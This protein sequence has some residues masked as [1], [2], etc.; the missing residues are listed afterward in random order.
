MF[1]KS[2]T[3]KI[4]LLQLVM[5]FLSGI[6]ANAQ[7]P[8]LVLEND[9][10]RAVFNARTGAL[11]KLVDKATDWDIQ[12]HEEFALSFEMLVPLKERRDNMVDGNKQAVRSYRI[13]AA[14]DSIVFLWDR[15]Q[16][17]HALDLPIRVIG[18]ASLNQGGLTFNMKIVNQS[19]Y[20]VEA[21]S[22]PSVGEITQPSADEPLYRMHQ[23][24]YNAETTPLLPLFYWGDGYWGVD[25][26]SQTVVMHES[27]YMLICSPK[28]GLYV[29]LHDL[30]MK[31]LLTCNFSLLPGFGLAHEPGTGE[32]LADT[33]D[34]ASHLQFRVWHMSYIN[35]GETSRLTPVVLNPYAGSWH[36]GIDNYKR[37][38]AGW[39][40]QPAEPAWVSDVHSWFELHENSPEQEW[41]IKYND[42]VQYGEDCAKN[43][44]KAIQL[45]GWN[46]G[47]QDGNN[48]SHD[49][50]PHLGTAEEFKNAI[51]RI[52]KLGVKIILFNKYIWADR[53][54]QWFRNEL[55]NYAM[56]DP[57]GDYYMFNGYQYQTAVQL[58]NINT[59][60]LVPMCPYSA[61]WRKIAINEFKKNFL[62]G[63]SGVLCDESSHRLPAYV[64][65]DKTHR[66]HVPAYGNGGDVKLETEFRQLISQ[67]QP[68]FLL[69]GEA[70]NDFKTLSY[71]LG[72]MRMDV[73]DHTP[74]MRYINPQ[75]PIMAGVAGFN[76]RFTLNACLRYKYIISY[77]PYNFKGRLGDFPL[78]LAYGQQIDSL[79]K[80]YKP[81]LWDAE[82]TDTLN[83]RVLDQ[84][85]VPYKDYSVF[86]AKDGKKAIV[87]VNNDQKKAAELTFSVGRPGASF[88]RAE[89]GGGEEN[90]TGNT[91]KVR[92]LS[93]VVIIEK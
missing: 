18:T 40:K 50:D 75:L 21:V 14:G 12:G 28:R 1:K 13:S 49:T 89:P 61:A 76:D 60:R 91:V 64:C 52:Q 72:Y 67:K 69:S 20:T 3:G 80:K 24:Y 5:I 68:D 92:P 26:P 27:P 51:S 71:Q 42:L 84:A 39:F 33:A 66:H 90:V 86:I 65:F 79:R 82:F 36:R 77:E 29:G 25:H 83:A 31:E 45:D 56:K 62:Y 7:P 53:S 48:P 37:W 44:V 2:F 58:A 32:A 35:P 16:S 54:T 38:R 10:I 17:E 88:I 57:Y 63:A 9:A 87:I 41:R 8:S 93:V 81:F 15:L 43:G 19:H 4:L 70:P 46:N 59:H 73:F 23:H 47:G 30:A 11:E 22:Y 55:I 78:T 74:L 6:L 34:H 85:N